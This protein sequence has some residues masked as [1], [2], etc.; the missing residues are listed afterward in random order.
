MRGGSRLADA[1][2]G[3]PCGKTLLDSLNCTLLFADWQSVHY[4]Q[5]DERGSSGFPPQVIGST[6]IGD[7]CYCCVVQHDW[8]RGEQPC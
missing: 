6:I 2:V 8:Q 1:L 3:R 7:K 5:F 4:E